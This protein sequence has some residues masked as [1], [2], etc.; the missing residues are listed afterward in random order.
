MSFENGIIINC[1]NYVSKQNE[2][3]NFKGKCAYNPSDMKYIGRVIKSRRRGY[4]R[5]WK[6]RSGSKSSY[7]KYT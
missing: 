6:R 7:C 4:R 3:E 1:E 5:L 2:A